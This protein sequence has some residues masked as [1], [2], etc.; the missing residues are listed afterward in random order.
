MLKLSR[1]TNQISPGDYGNLDSI[2]SKI[3]LKDYLK[4]ESNFLSP[5]PY[6][7]WVEGHTFMKTN[8]FISF[9][10]LS[11]ISEVLTI[12]FL[13]KKRML[14]AFKLMRTR[15]RKQLVLE[16]LTCSKGQILNNLVDEILEIKKFLTAESFADPNF[17]VL[18]I[19]C[20]VDYFEI[21]KKYTCV[22][23]RTAGEGSFVV[24]MNKISPQMN[25]LMSH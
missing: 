20:R 23:T 11:K 21:Q 5:V 1:P 4:F 14:S 7:F 13:I 18:E 9:A 16:I 15:V 19:I 10:E 8:V 6:F 12:K 3:F 17:L 2:L 22:V 24:Q 25:R